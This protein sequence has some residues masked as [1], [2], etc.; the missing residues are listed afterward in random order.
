MEV[1]RG[2]VNKKNSNFHVF[3]WYTSFSEQVDACLSTG[4]VQK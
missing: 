4:L 1:S 3:S 2:Y